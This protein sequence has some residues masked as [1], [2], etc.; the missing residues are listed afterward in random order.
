[1]QSEVVAARTVQR[2][3]V[4]HGSPP[5]TTR[6]QVAL[7]LV[8]K[9]ESLSYQSHV[10][11]SEGRPGLTFIPLNTIGVPRRKPD[12]RS[13]ACLR[14]I[15]TTVSSASDTAALYIEGSVIITAN[16]GSRRQLYV[17]DQRSRVPARLPEGRL[18]GFTSTTTPMTL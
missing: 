7:D 13:E 6:I 18:M 14:K 11:H 12:G 15:V 1:M 5:S 8:F 4:D 2:F 3:V 9:L 16:K 17:D 10:F